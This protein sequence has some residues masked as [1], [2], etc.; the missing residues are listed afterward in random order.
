M[1]SHC[2]ALGF[3][4]RVV[5]LSRD[6]YEDDIEKS[7]PSPF[8][9]AKCIRCLNPVRLV[10]LGLSGVGKAMGIRVHNRRDGE[11]EREP[12][13]AL[14]EYRKTLEEM[15]NDTRSIDHIMWYVRRWIE[16]E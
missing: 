1:L 7:W 10:L 6:I 5:K 3:D 12:K 8:F 14:E 9:I 11:E 2:R 16:R 15:F 4:T 13:D